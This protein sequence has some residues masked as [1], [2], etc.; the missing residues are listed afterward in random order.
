MTLL[1]FLKRDE[2]YVNVKTE[3]LLPSINFLQKLYYY[4][5][6]KLSASHLILAYIR[7]KEKTAG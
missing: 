5:Y 2:K 7:V 3:A 1:F 4:K 6:S